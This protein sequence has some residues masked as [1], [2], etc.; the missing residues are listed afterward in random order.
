MASNIKKLLPTDIIS[1]SMDKINSNFDILS[2][3]NISSDKSLMKYYNMIDELAKKIDITE[4]YINIEFEKIRGDIKEYNLDMSSIYQT[5]EMIQSTVSSLNDKFDGT[6]DKI[7]SQFTQT[8]ESINSVVQSYRDENDTRYDAITKILDGFQDQIDG[9]IETWYYKGEPKLNNEPVKTWIKDVANE[10]EKNKIYEKHQGDLYYDRVTGWAYRFFK[11]KDGYVW[12]LIRDTAISK[13]LAELGQ[14]AKIFTSQPTPSYNVGD[15]WI[16]EEKD[17]FVCIKEKESG[18]FDKNDWEYATRYKADLDDFKEKYQTDKK[19][20]QNQIDGKIQYWFQKDDPSVKWKDDNERSK[21]INDL[22]YDTGKGITKVYTKTD[23]GYEWQKTTDKDLS[24]LAQSAKDGNITIFYGDA[25]FGDNRKVISPAGYKKGDLWYDCTYPVGTTLT[26]NDN[27]YYHDTLRCQTTQGDSDFAIEHWV[28]I[29]GGDRAFSRISHDVDSINLEVYG[30]SE[31]G[32]DSLRSLITQRVTVGDFE[33]AKT[34]ITNQITTDKGEILAKFDSYATNDKVNGVQES[35]S[36][37]ENKIE[38]DN[39]TI[40]ANLNLKASSSELDKTNTALANLQTRVGTTETTLTQQATEI[41]D[42]KTAVGKLE[43]AIGSGESGSETSVTAALKVLTEK[44]KD[45]DSAISSLQSSVKKNGEDIAS[46]KIDISANKDN[47]TGLVDSIAEVKTTADNAASKLE[48]KSVSDKANANETSIS[49]LTTE[50]KGE[51]GKSGLK[52][53][54]ENAVSRIGANETSISGLSAKIGDDSSGIIS[55][56][57]AQ[58]TDIA[59]VKTAQTTMQS[60]IDD[61]TASIKTMVTKDEM[62]SAISSI[63]LDADRININAEHKLSI[64]SDGLFELISTNCTIDDQ[65]NIIAKNANISGNIT[66]NSLSASSG[67]RTTTINGDEFKIS[68]T[69]IVDSSISI[70]IIQDMSKITGATDAP[71]DLKTA[72]NVPTLCMTYNGKKY[73]MWPGAWK[74][75]S[76][77]SDNVNWSNTKL[78]SDNGYVSMNGYRLVSS[79]SDITNMLKNV[80]PSANNVA[81]YFIKNIVSIFNSASN[82]NVSNAFMCTK[83]TG[84]NAFG[85]KKSS[86]T[87]ETYNFAPSVKKLS[88]VEG[89]DSVWTNVTTFYSSI[90]TGSYVTLGK[91]CA[92]VFVQQAYDAISTSGNN[93]YSACSSLGMNLM[94]EGYVID[95]SGLA[96]NILYSGTSASSGKYNIYYSDQINKS[97]SL[98]MYSILKNDIGTA[99]GSTSDEKTITQFMNCSGSAITS[100]KGNQ[101][102][103]VCVY[104]I[105][106]L[107]LGS[108]GSASSYLYTMMSSISRSGL[109]S[110]WS[111]TSGLDPVGGGTSSNGE[112][113][114]SY[115]VSYEVSSVPSTSTERIELFANLISG[116]ISPFTVTIS[117]SGLDSST[118]RLFNFPARD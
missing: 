51:D 114:R 82:I 111:G 70:T 5:A 30:S 54:L 39:E 36:L 27:K 85:T 41:G 92:S 53:G 57:N 15:M 25:K 38:K 46:A 72:T 65:G 1:D 98:D 19:D 22:W 28:P 110:T 116:L 105:C 14:K 77:G 58:A 81:Q 2:A 49:N 84:Y 59:G 102:V 101:E 108:V 71:D 48:L 61:H 67:S 6:V 33:S 107:S 4:S 104:P 76:S 34:E 56:I 24:D 52:A 68:S 80:T 93:L 44:D 109:T 64:K 79:V 88:D 89:T 60:S 63:T 83:M 10:E 23:T 31:D 66:T 35:V 12:T 100:T 78:F 42:V 115:Y 75:L 97:F 86:S 40:T 17:L 9:N 3:Y 32:K 94:D 26:N 13:M 16:T 99:S 117:G 95:T 112:Y 20:F 37:L 91:Q 87:S 90:K 8:A 106:P 113:E 69:G 50:I 74:A 43:S 21:H 47:I 11:G 18:T 29:E 96:A 118:L 7:Q 45:H 55:Q 103:I 73:Y 62:N